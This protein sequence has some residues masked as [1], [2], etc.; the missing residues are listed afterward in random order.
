MVAC[1]ANQVAVGTIQYYGAVN[2][3]C[4][5]D[6]SPCGCNTLECP[7]PPYDA[8]LLNACPAC[9]YTNCSGCSSPGQGTCEGIPPVSFWSHDES[10]TTVCDLVRKVTTTEVSTPAW[11]WVILALFIV[12]ALYS[13]RL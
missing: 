6:S 1:E 10:C 3:Q 4:S 5:G 7:M 13:F 12:L 2:G 9:T 11:A 8:D